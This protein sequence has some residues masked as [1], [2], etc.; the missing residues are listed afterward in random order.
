MSCTAT[1]Q[2]SIG[3][4]IRTYSLLAHPHYQA[5]T[6]QLTIPHVPYRQQYP[7]NTTVYT[8]VLKSK[9]LI[10]GIKVYVYLVRKCFTDSL[11]YEHLI[12]TGNWYGY[13]IS[14]DMYVVRSSSVR[15]V[16]ARPYEKSTLYVYYTLRQIADL[17]SRVRTTT[18]MG[19]TTVRVLVLVSTVLYTSINTRYHTL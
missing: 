19:V 15:K 5:R 18:S 6:R 17:C 8:S 16:V 12:C 13:A 1:A 14:H 11:L 2:S 3:T 10:P 4:T 9:Y 7:Q